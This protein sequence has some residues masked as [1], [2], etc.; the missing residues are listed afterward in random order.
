MSMF[1]QKFW[2]DESIV[3]SLKT[4][5]I[6]KLVELW[7]WSLF[8][9]LVVKVKTF[10]FGWISGGWEAYSRNYRHYVSQCLISTLDLYDSISLKRHGLT[11]K[12]VS[13]VGIEP[14]LSV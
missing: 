4:S 10:L 1:S 7:Y 8:T 2:K 11:Q 9:F 3:S 14:Q 13:W 6:D 5:L 12:K